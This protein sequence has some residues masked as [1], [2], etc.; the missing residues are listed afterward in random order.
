METERRKPKIDSVNF[1]LMN[2]AKD[3]D[4]LVYHYDTWAANY[5]QVSHLWKNSMG[6]WYSQY[7]QIIQ[8]AMVHHFNSFLLMLFYTSGS[9]FRWW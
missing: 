6:Q 7:S 9:K 5:D 2:T 4:E 1:K 8:V 3:L